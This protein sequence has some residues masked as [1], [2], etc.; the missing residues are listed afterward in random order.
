MKCYNL[1]CDDHISKNENG[2]RFSNNKTE[3]C[4]GF[5]SLKEYLKEG[6]T[7]TQDIIV[8]YVTTKEKEKIKKVAGSKGMS[9]YLLDLHKEYINDSAK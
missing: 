1:C 2:C 6:K 3:G 8:V 7:H 5:I 9:K 4:I